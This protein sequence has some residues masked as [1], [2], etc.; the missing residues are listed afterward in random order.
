MTTTNTHGGPR[1]GAR[2]MNSYLVWRR[3]HH[4]SRWTKTSHTVKARDIDAAARKVEKMFADCGFHNMSL[5]PV[6]IG[7][8]P[9][10]EE[11]TR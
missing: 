7:N 6:P 2:Q 10:A 8:D 5:V 1:P 4:S 9:N 3:S 11:H